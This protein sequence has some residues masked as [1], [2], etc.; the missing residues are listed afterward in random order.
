MT[1]RAVTAGDVAGFTDIGPV[2]SEN[3]DA[4]SAVQLPDGAT[5][6]VLADGMGGHPGGREAA[7]GAL[8][9]AIVA[10]RSGRDDEDRLTAAVRAA[11]ES[12]AGLAARMGGGPGT[13]LVLALVREGRA[14]LANVGDSRAYLVASGSAV[15]ITEDHSWV[16][17]EVRAGRIQRAEIRRHLRRNVITRAVMGE[18]I[19]PD[20]FNVRLDP[21]SAVL[22][23][24]DGVWEPLDE[25]GIA[26]M[27]SDGEPLEAQVEQLCRAAVSAGGTD[28]VTAVAYREPPQG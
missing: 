9:A 4:W 8:E 2:R 11:N 14:T 23:C 21:G 28:N 3:Q 13:T 12:V 25:A 26:A 10:A 18:P 27:L 15:Q 6:L 16:A 20:L 22:L 1:E 17:D 24:S 19:A 5:L 7:T